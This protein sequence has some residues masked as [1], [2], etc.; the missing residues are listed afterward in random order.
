[1]TPEPDRARVDS[2][3]VLGGSPTDDELAAI[4]AVFSQLMAERDAA[5]DRLQAAPVPSEWSRRRRSLRGSPLE[6]ATWGDLP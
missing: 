2:P 1:M 4:V 6:N 5:H 3:Q